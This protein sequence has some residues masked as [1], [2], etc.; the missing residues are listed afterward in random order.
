[1]AEEDAD[2]ASR[3]LLNLVDTVDGAGGAYRN[4]S[5]QWCLVGDP[6]W[7]DLALIYL[8]ACGVLGRAPKLGVDSNRGNEQESKLEDETG[9]NN[10]HY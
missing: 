6:E 4:S 7:F 9:Q 8:E 1:V 10:H 2:P 5:G 3:A